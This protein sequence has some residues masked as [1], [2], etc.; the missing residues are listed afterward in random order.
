MYHVYAFNTEY[1]ISG[2][3]AVLPIDQLYP[4]LPTH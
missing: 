2:L 1:V 4:R 3:F